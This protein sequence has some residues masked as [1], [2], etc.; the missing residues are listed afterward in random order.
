MTLL[1]FKA[2]HLPLW[3]PGDY[4]WS[5]AMEHDDV[6]LKNVYVCVGLGHLAVQQKIDRML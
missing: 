6:R 4:V 5:L 2:A 1:L 3:S